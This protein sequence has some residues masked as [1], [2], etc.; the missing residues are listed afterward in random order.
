MQPQQLKSTMDYRPALL[1][2][3]GEIISGKTKMVVDEFGRRF[4][5][6]IPQEYYDTNKSGNIKW[7]WTVHWSRQDLV[8]AGMMASEKFGIWTITDAGKQFLYEHPDGG[9]KKLFNIIYQ[10]K[11]DKYGLG[12]KTTQVFSP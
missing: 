2:L 10:S 8:N 6:L 4:A 3:M 1:W 7:I 9:G 11:K 12:K 5:D